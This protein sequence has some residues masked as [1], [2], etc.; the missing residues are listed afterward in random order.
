MALI[1]RFLVLIP[2]F[3]SFIT[4]ILMSLVLFA[5]NQ[6]GFMEDYA[7]IRFNT[8][9]LGQTIFRNGESDN[10]KSIVGKNL[11]R[12]SL[13][14]A[15]GDLF[16]NLTANMAGLLGISDW[17]SIHIINACQ[18]EFVHNATSSGSL[19]TTSCTRLSRS[20]QFNLTGILGQEMTVG[21]FG[22]GLA[23]INWPDT[24]QN[25]INSFN[26]ALLAFYIFFVIGVGSSGVSMLAGVLVFFFGDKR[27]MLFANIIP[28]TL[29]AIIITLGCIIITSASSI[30]INAINKAGAKVT[31]VADKGVNFYI[32]SWTAAVFTM[33]STLFWITRLAILRKKEKEGYANF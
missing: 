9:V 1:Q 31:L 25:K 17:Y 23:D 5:G 2:L 6:Q 8:S 21:P 11:A 19:N 30:A 28:T 20:S 4:I 32:I 26:S 33:L 3:F 18:G 15:F 22:L 24:I 29:A 10:N 7:I 12:D 16:N 14:D 13:D 27:I